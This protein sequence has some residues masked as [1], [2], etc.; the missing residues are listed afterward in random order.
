MNDRPVPVSL[1]NRASALVADGD[2]IALWELL[3]NESTPVLLEDPRLAYHAAEA[4]YHTG[5]MDELAEYADAYERAA[6][7]AAD[8]AGT[9]KALNLGGIAAF[10]LGRTKDAEARFDLLMEL[11]EAEYDREM[12]ARAANNL[13]ALSNLKGRWHEAIAYYNLAI[14][15]Y[16]KL[17][18]TRGV[19]QS[20]HNLG[21]SYRDLDRLEDSVDAY[22]QSVVLAYEIDYQPLVAMAM[23]GRAE[24]ELRRGDGELARELA[25]RGLRL[26]RDVGDPISEAE[27]LRVCGLVRAASAEH[28]PDGARSDFREALRLA[29]ETGNTLLEAEVQRDLG[30]LEWMD[31]RKIEAVRRLEAAREHFVALGAVAAAREVKSDLASLEDPNPT[32]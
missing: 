12:L 19:A 20:L 27:A 29:R 24:T 23:T 6:R 32:S 5:R 1:R 11:A 9:M 10:E 3:R 16:Q 25:A 30:R 15:L 8:L 2:W 13:G 21:M 4:L 31:G 7:D 17:G 22:K 26:A 18:W 14:P 28:A